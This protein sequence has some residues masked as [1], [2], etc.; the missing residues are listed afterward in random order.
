MAV[1]YFAKFRS[2]LKEAYKKGL[3][4]TDLYKMADPIDP[5]ETQREPLEIEE[6]QLLASTP[7]TSDLLKRACLF[8]GLTGLLFSDAETL[9]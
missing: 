7:A 3:I 9:L 2:A 1:N 8:E 6:F 4:T 5:K